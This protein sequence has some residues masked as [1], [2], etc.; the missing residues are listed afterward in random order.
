MSNPQT[1]FLKLLT[2]SSC[3]LWVGCERHSS[4]PV[5]SDK[6]KV[7]VHVDTPA[8]DYGVHVEYPKHRDSDKE[9]KVKI[10]HD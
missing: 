5:K 4:T 1:A 3:L 10:E 8:G 2:I 9:T 7:D 6:G